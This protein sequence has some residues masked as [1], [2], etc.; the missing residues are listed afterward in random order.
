VDIA[1]MKSLAFFHRWV[2]V[3]LCLMFAT[4]FLS[5][6]VMVFVGFPSLSPEDRWERSE[7]VDLKQIQIA[8]A[9]ALS[10]APDSNRLRLLQYAGRPHYLLDGAGPVVVVD[11]VSGAV[12]S[13]ITAT[14][15]AQIA[16]QFAQT[17]VTGTMGPFDYDQW[18]VHQQFDRARPFYRV[19]L[20]DD[21]NTELYVSARSGELLQRTTA[22]ERGWNWVGSVVHWWYYT[23]IRKDWNLWDSAVW[24]LSLAGLTLAA[25]GMP[26]YSTTER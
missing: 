25:A 18:V 1:V 6:A 19:A 26:W 8:P 13:P 17:A 10:R 20:Q 22:R 2:G 3:L 15:A 21:A 4:W 14:T 9:A 11:A 24:W 16:K 5:G 23:A 12:Q 7:P